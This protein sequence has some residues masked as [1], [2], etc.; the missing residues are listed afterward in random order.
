MRGLRRNDQLF[1]GSADICRV[2]RFIR[3]GRVAGT[4]GASIAGRCHSDGEAE[5]PPEVRGRTEPAVFA[6]AI[7]RQIRGLEQALCLC[8]ALAQQPLQGGH[9]R[10]FV[11]A[12]DKRSRTHT[13][14]LSEVVDGQRVVEVCER[15]LQYR[16][17]TGIVCLG[18]ASS[19]Y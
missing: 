8:Y 3:S 7:D 12:A 4:K 19:T 5:V 16:T 9:S 10:C 15:P 11:E 1:Y 6:D 2:L 18:T 17:K 13:G 14:A